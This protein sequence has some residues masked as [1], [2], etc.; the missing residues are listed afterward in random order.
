MLPSG[1]DVHLFATGHFWPFEAP[2]ESVD[3]IRAFLDAV[4]G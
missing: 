3:V 1:S 2:Q 4:T